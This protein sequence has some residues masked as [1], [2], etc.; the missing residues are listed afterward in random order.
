MEYTLQ[1]PFEYNGK[2][3]EKVKIIRR[4]INVLDRIKAKTEAKSV[5]GTDEGDAFLI[6]LLN[7]LTDFGVE[8]PSLEL[9]EK[10][11]TEDFD[12]LI[13]KIVGIDE[14]FLQSLAKSSEN[15]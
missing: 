9:A 13:M 12:N 15:S 2:K 14:D 3:V 8:I 4:K 6:C 11:T 7:R 10:L 1:N 5:F